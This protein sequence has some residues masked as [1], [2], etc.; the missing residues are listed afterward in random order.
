MKKSLLRRLFLLC[1][2]VAIVS[3]ALASCNDKDNDPTTTSDDNTTSVTT[4]VTTGDDETTS[5]S[6]SSEEETTTDSLINYG[7]FDI[8]PLVLPTYE[9]RFPEFSEFETDVKYT[10]LPEEGVSK[11][12]LSYCVS[13]KDEKDGDI[14]DAA[15]KLLV[16]DRDYP[17]AVKVTHKFTENGDVEYKVVDVNGDTVYNGKLTGDAGETVCLT[18]GIKAHPTGYFKLIVGDTTIPYVVAPPLK[19]RTLDDSPFAADFAAYYH[20]EDRDLVFPVSSAARLMGITWIRDRAKWSWFE[21]TQGN[22][23]FTSHDAEQV[24][25]DIDRSGLK[26]LLMMQFT[27]YWIRDRMPMLDSERRPGGFFDTQLEAYE[28]VKKYTEHFKDYVDAW[29]IENEP[30]QELIDPP[31][32]YAA[33]FKAAALGA[34]DTNS[35]FILSHAGLCHANTEDDYTQL[36]LRN[37]MMKYS[38]MFNYHQHLQQTSTVFPYYPYLY[39]IK[40]MTS[41]LPLY[42]VC[43]K[44]V[45]M[46]ESGMQMPQSTSADT[47]R[48]QIGYVLT[49]TVQSLSAG[50]DKHFWYL[51][52]PDSP[53]AGD[54]DYG[55]FNGKFEPRPSVAVE[56]IMTQV[57]GEGKY[58]G[59]LRGMPDKSY[60]YLFKNGKRAVSVVWSDLKKGTYE[61]ETK[62]PVIVTD[63]MGK[64]TLI[65]PVDGKISIEFG[66]DPVYITYTIPPQ[67]YLKHELT[68]SKLKPIEITDG[69]RVVITPEFTGYTSPE[70]FGG[71][72]ISDG[73]RINVRVANF[74]D[75]AV[76]GTVSVTIPGYTVEG[77]DKVVTV[78]P[79]QYGFITLTLHQNEEKTDVN[80]FVTFVGTFNG[81]ETSAAAIHVRNVSGDKDPTITPRNFRTT[82]SFTRSDLT[83]LSF[84]VRNTGNRAPTV[85]F[86]EEKYDKFTLSERYLDIDI[87]GIEDGKY[88]I[89]VALCSEGGDY[90]FTTVTM[91]VDGE[92]ITFR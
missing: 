30:E 36:L 17:I 47:L 11:T 65:E 42:G 76:S 59:E 21:Q 85:L 16:F 67:D 55:F 41:T 33:W 37:D 32:I 77:L 86:N 83:T 8:T 64:N 18:R 54:N 62:G 7:D 1:A 56:M 45:W 2:V 22:V 84:T 70:K 57:L 74:N 14:L 26:I 90:T 48:T 80:D 72:M 29:E 27:P 9:D 75:Y 20:V 38:S 40:S 52:V 4:S 31:E 79:F 89:T 24:Y 34:Y 19:D 44:P 39:I 6:S 5:E 15:A 71:H 10:V 87:N 28:F 49:S 68:E 69:D 91:L 3:V 61:F 78:A 73:T 92:N 88:V 63:L 23:D 50:T 13:V 46:S 25:S 35:S 58:L 43:D 53:N 12:T 60:G 51:M 66:V 81:K 82:K